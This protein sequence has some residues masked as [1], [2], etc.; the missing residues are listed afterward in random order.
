MTLPTNIKI[1]G[2]TGMLHPLWSV[3]LKGI[4]DG[5]SQ[6]RPVV[7]GYSTPYIER[8]CGCL[9][10]AV[11][12]TCRKVADGLEDVF[13]ETARDIQ[14]L[15]TLRKPWATEE[16]PSGEEGRRAAAAGAA[17]QR[18]NR[19]RE[20]E[21]VLRLEERRETIQAASERLELWRRQACAEVR[22]RL[23]CYWDG[24]LKSSGDNS[25][26]PF[27]LEG[28]RETPGLTGVRLQIDGALAQISRALSEFE[29]GGNRN[30]SQA[31]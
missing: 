17:L 19:L 25:L 5:K 3:R 12:K 13:T 6:V 20:R 1:P 30:D 16:L 21:L 8:I 11:N 28:E 27:P 10:S 31:A 15:L 9:H 24:V 22:I 2:V 18:A 4:R 26:P 29:K 14:E 23:S 7:G